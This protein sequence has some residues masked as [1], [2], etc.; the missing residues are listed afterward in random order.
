MSDH[1]SWFVRLIC[2]ILTRKRC[3]AKN[4]STLLVNHFSVA[5]TVSLSSWACPSSNLTLIISL[6]LRDSLQRL[7][8]TKFPKTDGK[9][10]GK[11]VLHVYNFIHLSTMLLLNKCNMCRKVYKY[12]QFRWICKHQE[13]PMP[14]AWTKPTKKKT[15]IHESIS[16]LLQSQITSPSVTVTQVA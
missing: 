4:A 8:V 15:T 10:T 9:L 13:L 12:S 16:S 7:K 5:S 6:S 11:K 14:L 2:C 3:M 1:F